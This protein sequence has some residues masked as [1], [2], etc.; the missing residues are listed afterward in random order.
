M[1]LIG[2]GRG[3]G[4]AFSESPNGFGILLPTSTGWPNGKGTIRGSNIGFAK[5]TLMEPRKV[6]YFT[7]AIPYVLQIHLNL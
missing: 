2:I 5:K 3:N 1:C 6:V 7:P 4:N